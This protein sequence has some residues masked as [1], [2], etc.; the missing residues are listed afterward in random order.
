MKNKDNVYFLTLGCSKND[1]DTEVMISILDKNL[2]TVVDNPESAD[3]VVVN[4]CSF[5]LDAKTQSIETLFELAELKK[6][7]LKYLVVAG[8]LGQ[9]YPSDLLDE[10]PELDAI[11]GTGEIEKI[12][13]VFDD[14]KNGKREA[15]VG[16]I[17]S[18]YVE[19]SKRVDFKTT[20]FVKISEGCN[21]HCTYCIIPE[22]RGRMRSRPIENILDEVRYLAEHGTKEIILI[23]QNTTD[24]GMDIYGKKSLAKLL[25]VLNDVDGITWIRVLYMYPEGFNDE[26][27]DA[28][29]TCDK[30]CKYVDMPLQHIND[31]VLKL[32]GRRITKAE[33][34]NLIEKLRREIP[35]IIIRTTLIVGFVNETEEAFAELKTFIEDAELDKVGVFQYS[36]EEGTPA[37]KLGDKVSEDDKERRWNE[38]MK[39]QSEISF[40]K[41]HSKIGKNYKALIEKKTDDSYVGRTYMDAPG[42]DGL[43]YINSHNKLNIGDFYDIIVKDNNEYDIYAEEVN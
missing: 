37:Y 15:Y 30:V 5:I 2:Y 26:L 11:I 35:D 12:N 16:N 3:I 33:T 38:I 23:A 29:K 42:I 24:Y 1:I 6:E 31:Q 17:N 32:M 39:L 18:P 34:Y 41:L 4:T 10:I 28:I 36:L 27:I 19:Q 43:V 13:F 14:I 9:R 21:N 25:K 20:Q 8:C 22:L 7:N 40:N